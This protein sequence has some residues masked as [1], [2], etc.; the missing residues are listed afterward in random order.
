MQVILAGQEIPSFYPSSLL[1]ERKLL[2]RWEGMSILDLD[3]GG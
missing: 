3:Q 2:K 1:P